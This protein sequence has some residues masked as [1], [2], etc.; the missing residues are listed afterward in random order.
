MFHKVN[1]NS[2]LFVFT[3]IK[4]LQVKELR[5]STFTS[6][7]TN[8]SYRVEGQVKAL[9]ALTKNK[10]KQASKY[11]YT[12]KIVNVNSQTQLL[13]EV[14]KEY[15]RTVLYFIRGFACKEK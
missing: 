9:K 11:Q 13:S 10:C 8:A 5:D 12:Y 2:I 14:P 3:R 7:L 15:N 4:W 6:L 1:T